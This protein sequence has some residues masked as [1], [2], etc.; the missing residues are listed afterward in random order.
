MGFIYIIKNKINNKVYIG[1]TTNTVQYRFAQHLTNADLEYKNGHLYNAMKKYGKENFYVETIEE[2]SNKNL[3][4][5]EIYWIAY[6]SFNNGY[7]STI[8]GEGNK[9]I[10]YEDV[11]KD[12]NNGLTVAN[13]KQKYNI[14]N[15]CILKIFNL[16]NISFEERMIRFGQSKQ[17]NTDEKILELW[18]LGY[19]LREIKKNFGGSRDV[20]KKQL[21][22]Q[23]ITEEEIWQRGLAKRGRP[24]EQYSLNDEYIA[25]YNTAAEAARALGHSNGGNIGSAAKGQRATAYGYKWKYK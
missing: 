10:N 17:Q 2:V 1:Q 19:G 13:I 11:I 18:N 25:T 6:D 14:S 3:N 15:A 7:N 12:W 23:G 24:V 5:R 21:L 4:E 20:I 8:G 16:Y 22:R 9:K